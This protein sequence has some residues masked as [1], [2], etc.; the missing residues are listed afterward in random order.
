MAGTDRVIAAAGSV[1]DFYVRQVHADPAK[2]DVVYNAV[3]FAEGRPTISRLEMRAS[4][5]LAADVRVAAIVAR[6]TRQ[7]GHRH[8][9]K[10][11]ASS[12]ALADVQLLV[13]GGGEER[14]AL[15]QD[16]IAKGLS[17]RVRFLGVRRDVGNL[18]GAIDV[19]VLPSLW[20]G[21]PLAMVHAMGAGVPVVASRVAGIPEVVDDGR[22]GLL[23][24]PSDALALGAALTRM[25][26]DPALR[27]RIG[28]DGSL[29]VLQRFGVDRYVESMTSLYDTLLERVA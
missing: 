11:L 12:P 17:A 4:L 24:P 18:L 28:H 10:A 8:L 20:E 27:E 2:V 25:F 13:I 26:D 22:T 5:G 9:F 23:V 29:S 19:F 14:E 6:L 15:E 3:D 1:R 7:K 21:L 16:A